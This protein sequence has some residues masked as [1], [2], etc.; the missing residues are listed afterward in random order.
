SGAQAPDRQKSESA[1]EAQAAG[2]AARAGDDGAARPGEGAAARAGGGAA[3][4]GQKS[5]PAAGSSSR[6]SSRG[7]RAPVLIAGVVILLLAGAGALIYFGGVPEA[8]LA[9]GSDSP[10]EESSG[11]DSGATAEGDESSSPD[12]PSPGGEGAEGVSPGDNEETGEEETEGADNE[13]VAVG[14]GGFEVTLLDVIIF[15]NRVAEIN[16][17]E[18]LGAVAPDD[19]D[20]D[21]IFPG[22]RLELPDGS[23]RVVQRGDTMWDISREFLLRYVDEHHQRFLELQETAETGEPPVGELENLLEEVYVESL[24]EAITDFLESL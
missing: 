4:R 21:W 3:A 8:L 22:N 15:V 23:V 16:G 18:P 14:N 11:Q 24:R 20:P 2:G 6:E 12:E 5:S 17:Y 1:P 19:R 10:R 13:T 9:G 7:R